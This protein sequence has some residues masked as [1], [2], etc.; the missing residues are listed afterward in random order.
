MLVVKEA[1]KDDPRVV[2]V[3]EALTSPELQKFIED[4]FK[5]SVLPAK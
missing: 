1:L 5:G 3:N 2:K 4:S